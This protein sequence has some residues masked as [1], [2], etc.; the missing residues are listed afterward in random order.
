VT[1]PADR[2][3]S[4]TSATT[5]KKTADAKPGSAV[6]RI[7]WAGHRALATA[8]AFAALIHHRRAERGLPDERLPGDEFWALWRTAAQASARG[9]QPDPPVKQETLRRIVAM[10]RTP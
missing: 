6:H 7:R 1:Q 9:W 2:A 3:A 8:V 5:G 10:P 4:R